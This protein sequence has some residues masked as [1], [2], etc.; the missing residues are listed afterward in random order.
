MQRH[1]FARLNLARRSLRPSLVNALLSLVLTIAAATSA[2]GEALRAVALKDVVALALAHN[3]TLG[4]AV[5]DVDFAEGQLRAARG[6]DDLSLDASSTWTE[7]RR[8]IVAGT[9]VQTT[10]Y[11]DVLGWL[12]LTQPLPT[13][14]KIGLRLQNEWTLSQ[15]Q[16]QRM[17]GTGFDPS[18]STVWAP[19]LQ[20]VLSHS[21][22][23]GI[24]IHVARA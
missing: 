21:L 15:F 2:D 7:N 4:A 18:T 16:T 10:A 12:Q 9:P 11:D 13:G 24:G 5:A 19:S 23:R 14:G 1:D 6:L 3:P 17:D 20:L 8:P 22:L